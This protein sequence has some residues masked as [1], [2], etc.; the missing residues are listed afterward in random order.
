M[1][2]LKGV[3]G[4]SRHFSRLGEFMKNLSEVHRSVDAFQWV[5]G[6]FRRFCGALKEF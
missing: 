5:S 3:E 4:V 2:V 1:R 6:G